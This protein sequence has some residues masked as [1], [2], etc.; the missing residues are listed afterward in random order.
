MRFLLSFLLLT[1]VFTSNAQRRT[2]FSAEAPPPIGPYSQGVLA[3]N[4]LYVAGQIALVG[5][6]GQL[7]NGS[8]RA[9]T[10]QVMN[11]LAA[12]LNAADMT[13][14]H[15]VKVTIYVQDLADF[16]AVNAVYAEFFP[17]NPP[18]RE[19]VQ[20]AA[21]PRGAKVEISCVAVK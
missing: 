19:T 1:I 14:A 3:G 21:L 11:N 2:V 17:E 7:Q 8:I 18:A 16:A 5:S 4:T 10:L 15:V 12:I 6:T 13:F 9:E 20:V